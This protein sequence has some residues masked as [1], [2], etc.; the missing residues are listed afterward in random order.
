M[1]TGIVAGTA[2][3]V[4]INDEGEIR[5]IVIDLKGYDDNLKIGASVSIEGVCMTVVS[6]E[7]TLVGFDAIEETLSRTTL[8]SLR[9]K[10]LVNI[11]RSM[12]VGDE[13]GGH[14]L[15]GHIF[16][17][18]RILER[19]EVGES[20]NLLI[21]NPSDAS[22]FIMEKG[23]VAIDGISLTVGEVSESGFGLHIIPETKRVTTIRNKLAGDSVNLEVDSRTQA[24]VE[25]VMRKFGE[26]K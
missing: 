6:I 14:V 12:R 11:E 9:P 13:I 20:L 10:D 3:V 24:V 17:V 7:G 18:A 19:E 5:S 21:E 22:I 2:P 16:T 25:T 26:R 8:G 1:Y 23:F 15:S 4:S